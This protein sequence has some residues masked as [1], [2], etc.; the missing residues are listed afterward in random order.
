MAEEEEVAAAVAE[1]VLAALVVESGV[2]WDRRMP[3]GGCLKAVGAGSASPDRED[4]G[5]LKYLPV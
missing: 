2:C 3:G 5:N 4:P 1:E